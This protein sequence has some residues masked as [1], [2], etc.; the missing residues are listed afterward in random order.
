MSITTQLVGNL[1][2]GGKPFAATFTG[3]TNQTRTVGESGKTYLVAA[4]T[5]G[6]LSATIF[7][8]GVIVATGNDNTKPLNFEGFTVTTGP[9]TIEY[10]GGSSS[11]ATVVV[12]EVTAF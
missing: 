7:A 10:T 2:G 4:R 8:N 3:R 5:G 1:G 12:T 11:F 6:N 9:V